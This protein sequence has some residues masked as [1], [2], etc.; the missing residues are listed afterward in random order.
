MNPCNPSVN[1]CLVAHGQ[2]LEQWPRMFQVLSLFCEWLK[3]ISYDSRST[4]LA[5]ASRETS[6]PNT[7]IPLE[8]QQ[9]VRVP[10]EDIQEASSQQTQRTT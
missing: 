9:L 3:C 8:G 5:V 10:M 7:Q 1:I 6:E 2:V 4:I